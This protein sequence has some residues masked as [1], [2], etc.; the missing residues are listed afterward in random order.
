M[1]ACEQ[2][3]IEPPDESKCLLLDAIQGALHSGPVCLVDRLQHG[4]QLPALAG[5][6]DHELL[7]TRQDGRGRQGFAFASQLRK[8]VHVRTCALG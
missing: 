1:S 3:V 6:V 2:W 7:E 5:D 8:K 4:L